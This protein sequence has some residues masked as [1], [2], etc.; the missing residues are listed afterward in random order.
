MF[1]RVKKKNN[2]KVAIQV[3]DSVRKGNQV[4]QKIVRHFGMATTEEEVAEYKRI[5]EASILRLKRE[6]DR[7]ISFPLKRLKRFTKA[8]SSRL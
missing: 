4:Q 1:V 3:V 8:L 7:E 2:G 6:G 5:A